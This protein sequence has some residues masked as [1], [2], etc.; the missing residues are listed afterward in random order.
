[1]H[2]Y[3]SNADLDVILEIARKHDLIVVEDAAHA[4]GGKWNG[5]GL[6]SHGHVGSFS[7]Q[8]SKTMPSGESGIC[9]TND[10]DIAEKFFRM[11]HIGYAPGAEQGVAKS[12]PPIGLICR[13]YRGNEFHAAILQDQLATLRQRIA[14]YNV[15]AAKLEQRLADVAGVRVQSRGWL[16]D[17]QSYYQF[18]FI[19]D[20]EP[21]SDVS[22]D[23]IV[24][25]AQ[26]EGLRLWARGYGPVYKHKLWNVPPEG[27]RVAEGGCPVAATTGTERIALFPHYVLGAEDEIIDQIGDIL[28]KVAMNA[29][30]LLAMSS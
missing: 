17:P 21:L 9:I 3:G 13:N 26:A 27:Y 10:D 4:H 15:N 8:Q 12:G 14:R 30:A 29:D 7:F 19:F 28:V 2:L 1:V 11:K 5:K 25:A 16:A 22:I 23:R 20:Q 18:V 24:E 6:G